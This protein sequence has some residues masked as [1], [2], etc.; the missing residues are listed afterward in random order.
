MKKQTRTHLDIDG[1]LKSGSGTILRYSLALSCIL[2]ENLHIHN[3]RA[4]RKKP[5]LMAQHVRTVEACLDLTAGR[6]EGL[7]TQSPEIVFYPGPVT[8]DGHFHWNIGTAG[9]TTL[10]AQCLLPVGLFAKKASSYTINGGLFQDFAPSP[11]HTKYV[12]MKILNKF[13]AQ[14]DLTVKKPGYVPAG[15]GEIML[16]TE[17]VKTP[18]QPL[19]LTDQGC[20]THVKGIALSSHLEKQKVSERMA[21]TC[22]EELKKK[23][24]IDADIEIIHDEQSQ[25]K[26]A[27][28]FICAETDTG[29]IIGADM[30]GAVG[31][32]SEKIGTQTAKK[33]ID[34]LESG[35]TVDRFTADQ[36]I[37]Y[38]ALAKGTSTYIIPKMTDH[39]E[40]R[41]WL[42]EKMLGAKTEVKNNRIR[43][44]GIG[45]RRE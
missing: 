9:S 38:A 6:A 8:F 2:K 21:Q 1:S 23:K 35:A 32:R 27:A 3:I 16:E 22:A 41:L 5:G 45:Y 17:P 19:T 37:L 18:L 34:D 43:I 24:N 39:I 40:T 30:A 11:Y 36:L 14:A 33:L 12:L 15:E 26:G 31:R 20:I 10:M 25:Q 28:L 44:K 7:Y 29:C 42:V 13:S 4:Q